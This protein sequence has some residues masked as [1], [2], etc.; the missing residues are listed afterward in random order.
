MSAYESKTMDEALGKMDDLQFRMI[1]ENDEER[2]LI[3][4]NSTNSSFSLLESWLKK[5]SVRSRAHTAAAITC[6]RLYHLISVPTILLG[7]TAAGLAFWATSDENGTSHHVRV[8]VASLSATS[9][10]FA[11]LTRLFRFNEIGYQ[12]KMAAGMYSQ[13]C[14]K[15]EVNVFSASPLTSVNGIQTLLAEISVQFSNTIAFSPEIK[16]T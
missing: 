1:E 11:S 10:M 7:G 15:I 2:N 14:R 4:N 12:H 9:T 16:V 5:C 3:S 13:L 6:E 8:L